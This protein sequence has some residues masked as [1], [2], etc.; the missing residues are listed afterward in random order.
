M[1]A[2]LNDTL[3]VKRA[4]INPYSFTQPFWEGTREKKLMIQYCPVAKKYQFFPRP[5]SIFTGSRDLEWREVSGKGE[6]YSYTITERARPPFG[7]NEPF[8]IGLVNLDEG[9]RIMGNLIGVERSSIKIGMRLKPAWAPLSNGYN[10]L[11][12]QPDI[13]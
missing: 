7:G 8:A 2:N 13:N 6:L 12:F 3:N 5:V 1:S 4:D 10:V 9:V 11:L